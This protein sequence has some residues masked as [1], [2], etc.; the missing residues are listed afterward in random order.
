MFGCGVDLICLTA[1]QT[2]WGMKSKIGNRV[3]TLQSLRPLACLQ[4]VDGSNIWLVL[5]ARDKDI[6]MGVV[7]LMVWGFAGDLVSER[8]LE[9]YLRARGDEQTLPPL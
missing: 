7:C 4:A 5:L 1:P 9:N 8:L 3:H 6:L 2:I